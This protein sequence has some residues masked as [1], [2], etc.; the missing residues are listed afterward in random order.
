VI[1][2]ESDPGIGSKNVVDSA[3]ASL[4][5][6]SFMT[7]ICDFYSVKESLHKKFFCFLLWKL[8]SF[9]F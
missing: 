2:S 8:L 7:R 3:W 6:V 4:S 5:E 9:G 1:C